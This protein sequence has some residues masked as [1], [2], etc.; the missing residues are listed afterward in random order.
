MALD[1]LKLTFRDEFNSLSLDTGTAAT[2][3]NFWNSSMYN[4]TVRS[5]SGNGELEWYMDPDYKGSSATPLNVN[6]FEINNGILSIKARPA[7]PEVKK[8]IWGYNYTSGVLTSAG[9]FSQQYGYFE[10][11]AQVP[12]GKGLWPAFWL[13]ADHGKWPPELDVME[14]I[15]D[16]T[17]YVHQTTHT[18]VGTNQGKAT[19]NSEKL[20]AGYHTY[21]MD[22]TQSTITYYL[23]GKATFSMATPGDMNTP[24]YML[25]NLAVGGN[26]PG[27]PDA[28]TNWATANYNVDYV[29]VYQHSG[30]AGSGSVLSPTGSDPSAPIPVSGAL[31]L[32]ASNGLDMSGATTA[33][34]IAADTGPS[35]TRTYTAAQMGLTD[36]PASASMTVAYDSSKNVTLTNNAAWND[37]K[38]AALQSATITGM[39]VN[40]FVAVQIDLTGNQDGSINVT[41]AKRGAITTGSGND[42]ITVS[43]T[44]NST[45]NSLM[46]ILAGDGAN[47]ISF[48]GASNTQVSV[49]TGSGNDDITIAGQTA[50][51][52]HAGAGNDM[53]RGGSGGDNLD[54]GSGNDYFLAALS[55]GNDTYTG[56]DGWDILDYSGVAGVIQVNQLAGTTTGSANNDILA[57]VFEQIIG[58]SFDDV[59]SGGHGINCI[60]GGGGN[61]LIFGNN[62]DDLL[63]GGSGN[64]RFYASVGDGNDRLL[65]GDGWDVLD[66]STLGGAVS[67]NQVAGNTSGAAGTDTLLDTFEQVIG[68]AYNDTILGG[69][70]GEALSGGAGDDQIVGNGGNDWISGDS[71]NNILT[72]G[73]GSDVFAFIAGAHATITDFNVLEDRISLGAISSSSLNVH[74]S[75]NSTLIDLNGTT[76]MTLAGITVAPSAITYISA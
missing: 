76:V 7:A 50:S 26:W 59:L 66:Y 53:I 33:K 15:G 51:T 3:A 64:D 71:G 28:T 65:G 34:F 72:G 27:S 62:G 44:S 60:D 73:A 41:G 61:D 36:A 1:D 49:T 2:K 30:I 8:A 12:E 6:P 29:R 67:V 35:T 69:A 11:R 47:K 75:G 31:Q 63:R 18:A 42:T 25:L 45:D 16:S 48:T 22:W 74:L 24:M 40:N 52:V 38:N 57:D 32:I 9:S 14:V 13:L 17:N 56:G 39:T 19:W 10:V 23:D 68:S 37:I 70:G 55:D 4:G 46:T 5:L 58:S 20:S 43:A 21:G 54:G